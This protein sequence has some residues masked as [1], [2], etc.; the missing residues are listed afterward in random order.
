MYDVAYYI[1]FAMLYKWSAMVNSKKKIDIVYIFTLQYMM[2]SSIWFDR[3]VIH[4]TYID[5]NMDT[6]Y[7]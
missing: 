3:K 5:I 7:L 2:H 6:V 1:V 4:L